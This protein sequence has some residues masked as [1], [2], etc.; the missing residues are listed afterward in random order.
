[1]IKLIATD[2]DGTL[3]QN[4]AQSLQPSTLK[5]IKQL[6]DKGIIF[7]AASGRQY[8]NLKRLFKGIDHNMVF[9]CENGSL[10][11]YQDKVIKK[12]TLERSLGQ[13]ILLDISK[14]P[15][16]E[17]LLSGENTCYIENHDTEYLVHMR[18]HV[19]NNVTPVSDIFRVKEDYLKISA[20]IKSGVSKYY[21]DH[22]MNNW[23]GKT[24]CAI[25]GFDWFDFT[26]LGTNKGTAIEKLQEL[27]HITPDECMAFGDNYNDIEMLSSVQYSYAMANAK[28]SVKE[29]CKYSTDLVEKILRELL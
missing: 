22:F 28:P 10:V 13:S 1:M 6:M 20:Y 23:N 16:C 18:D 15:G 2:L 8:P 14:E 29:V 24:Q 21:E 3:L 25:A 19:K 7:V 11:M 26:A 17:I 9:L 27:F 4:G 12:S 5:L